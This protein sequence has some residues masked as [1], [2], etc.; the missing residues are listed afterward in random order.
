MV[1]NSLQTDRENNQEKNNA[2][3]DHLKASKVF[4]TLNS[5]EYPEM[6]RHKTMILVH[7]EFLE[8]TKISEISNHSTLVTAI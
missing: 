3:F 7:I 1:S 6:L 2:I 5:D 4:V 8:P